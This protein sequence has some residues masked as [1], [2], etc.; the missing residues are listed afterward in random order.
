[1]KTTVKAVRELLD[2]AAKGEEVSLDDL[3]NAMGHGDADDTK[4]DSAL[5]K[6]FTSSG[7][8][9][10]ENPIVTTAPVAAA[11]VASAVAETTK[12]SLTDLFT[13]NIMVSKQQIA[14]TLYLLEARMDDETCKC[15][16]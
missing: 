8:T 10:P 1:M 12:S 11:T 9:V 13:V 5:S 6:C 14:N 15:G 7:V 16:S 2:K 3:S 4:K